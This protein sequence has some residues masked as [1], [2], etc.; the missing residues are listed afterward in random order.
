MILE[1][2]IGN[3][4]AKWRLQDK[5]K[6]L[7]RGKT[8]SDVF[9]EAD[10]LGLT[11]VELVRLA[12]V[13]AVSSM[14]EVLQRLQQVFG[15][16]VRRAET[17]AAQ[18]GV[19]NSYTNPSMMGVDRWLAMLAAYNHPLTV[20]AKCGCLV[21]SCGTAVTVDVLRVDGVHQ[22]GYILPGLFMMRDALL[23]RTG[24]IQYVPGSFDISLL[25][26]N[27]T[28]SAVEHGAVLAVISAIEQTYKNMM[29]RQSGASLFITGG[30]AAE[31]CGLLSVPCYHIEELVLDGL[32]YALPD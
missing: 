19:S 6:T 26:G 3:T 2:D 12:S 9:P 1:I 23:S 18:A 5:Q 14:E 32:Q 4:W 13:K 17:Q 22:G 8:R 7:I 16:K 30:D 31:L 15:N 28:A 29:E 10:L 21:V 11:D 20:S 25:P 24:R 27:S